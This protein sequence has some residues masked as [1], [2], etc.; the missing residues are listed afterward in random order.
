VAPHPDLEAEQA[1]LDRAYARLEAMRA[2]AAEALAQALEAGRGGTPQARTERDVVVRT[3]LQRLAELDIGERPL[4]F[5]RI[6]VAPRDGEPGASYHLGRIGV[7]G[8]DHEPLVVDWRAPVAEPFYRATGRDPMGL[9]LRRHFATA[10]RRLVGIE[11]EVFD[12]DA[13][14]APG[15]SA[16]SGPA[17]ATAALLGALE[18]PRRGRLADIVATIQKEQDEVIRSPLPGVLVV[19]GGPGTGKTAVALHR[20]A[21]VLYTYRFPLERQGVLVVGPNPVFLRYI[22]EVLPSLGETGVALSTVEGLVPRVAVRAEE[23]ASLAALKGDARMATVVA[24]AVAG[25]ERAL[26]RDLEVPVGSV[27]A[28]LPAERSAR[29]V[30][31]AR[32]RPGPHNAKREL[33]ERL[34]VRELARDALAARR[35]LARSEA[36]PEAPVDE[37]AL[38]EELSARPEVQ[39]ALERMWP[40]LTPEELLHDLFGSRPLLALAG[41]GVLTREERAAMVRP[42]SATAEQIPWTRADLALLDEARAL[43]GPRR[44]GKDDG[45]RAYGHVVVDE[46]QDLSPMELRMIARRSIS[47]SITLAGDLAQATGPHAP[48]GWEEVC[49][50]VAPGRPMRVVELTVNYR[51]PEAVMALATRVLRVAAPG[52]RPP[53][54][55]RRSGSRPVLATVDPT[56]LDEE[57][58]RRTREALGAAGEGTVGV[59]VPPSLR[60]RVLGVLRGA[61][62]P[63]GGAD[64]LGSPL[65]VVPVGLAKGLEFDAV[66]VV[67]PGLVVE[68]IPQ[69]LRA[70]YVALTRTTRHLVVVASR[71]LPEALVGP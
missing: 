4:C 8:P 41:R 65:V 54:S 58:V 28:R 71:P 2:S 40:R 5:G 47:G 23:P 32:R 57:L 22:G 7:S 48:S 35:R 45:P 15:A 49:R 52:L 59:L 17:L 44:Q 69:G 33:V 24:R 50:H 19:Q 10:G 64:A 12:P 14:A 70:L 39:A 34:V 26:R 30:A 27:V 21:Y 51:T 11:D 36:A 43:L 18:R 6:D 3:S 63:A 55:I 62:L 46:A 61:G 60:E 20:A 25:R 1:Y 38:A 56:R 16:A 13:G 68:E 9:R 67:E 37:E 31:A 66:V 29:I 53:V 42:R